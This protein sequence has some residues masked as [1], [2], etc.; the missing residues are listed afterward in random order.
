MTSAEGRPQ[1]DEELVFWSSFFDRISPFT[2]RLS[3]L[4]NAVA[5]SP[6][7]GF[8]DTGVQLINDISDSAQITVQR[9]VEL[10][11]LSLIHI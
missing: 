5:D 9:V 11:Y 1:Q 7:G 4:G 2:D 8:I 6:V 3:S 10:T